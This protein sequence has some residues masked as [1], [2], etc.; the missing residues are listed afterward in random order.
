MCSSDLS[1]LAAFYW[2]NGGFFGLDLHLRRDAD[3]VEVI[4]KT[5]GHGRGLGFRGARSREVGAS[6]GREQQEGDSLLI[7]K[8]YMASY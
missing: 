4:E 2:N 5:G 7:A 6:P 8:D 1:A 3:I